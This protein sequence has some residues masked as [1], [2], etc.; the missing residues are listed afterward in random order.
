GGG[1]R[2]VAAGVGG[3]LAEGGAL[4]PDRRGDIVGAVAGAVVGAVAGAVVT[5]A[6][7]GGARAAHRRRR[8]SRKSSGC[9]PGRYPGDRLSIISGHTGPTCIRSG[10]RAARMLAGGQR[11]DSPPRPGMVS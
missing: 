6:P 5:A 4:R 8:G 1:T 2:H 11:P 10:R 9:T 7:G 3:G